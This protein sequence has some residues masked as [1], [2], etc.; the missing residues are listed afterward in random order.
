M[1]LN[2]SDL[3]LRYIWVCIIS[4]IVYR[5]SLGISVYID[6]KER[7]ISG[8]G[9]WSGLSLIF[10][11]FVS[12]I[13]AI[14]NH[15][16]K[17]RDVI[18]FKSFFVVSVFIALF[19]SNTF[20]MCYEL[21]FTGEFGYMLN[22]ETAFDESTVVTFENERGKK[23]ILDKMGNEYTFSNRGQFLYYEEDGTSYFRMGE[24]GELLRNSKTEELLSDS[25][26]D[27]YINDDGYLCIFEDPSE[28]SSYFC[29]YSSVY[30]D[31]EHLY[32][33]LSAVSWDRDG[34]IVFPD[35]IHE[36]NNLTFDNVVNG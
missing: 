29:E 8:K 31:E 6:G 7:D 20:F 23:V 4:F 24:F 5:L 22:P 2:A 25:D 28:L 19:L 18:K 35:Y 17:D 32:F 21:S 15:K 36:M 30:Y 14:C 12:I 33:D 1:F 10:G 3:Q 16:K 11:A 34:E 26:Y 13:Y 27:F 9:W